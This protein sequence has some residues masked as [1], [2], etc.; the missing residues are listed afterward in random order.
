MRPLLVLRP[1]PGAS[2]TVAAGRILGLDTIAA[3]LFAIKPIGWTL[4]DWRPEAVLLTSANAVRHGGAALAALA[5]LPTYAVGAA[6]A[7]AAR[8]AGFTRIVSG[9]GD[10]EVILT[11]AQRD[12][13]RSL[14]HPTGREHREVVPGDIRIVRHIVYAAQAVEVLPEAARDAL[15]DAVALLHSSRA[16]RLFAGFVDPAGIAIA[17]ISPAVLAAAGPGWRLA[18]AADHPTDASLLAV[19]A[20]L[21]NHLS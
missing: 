5:D 18:E 1:E 8:N 15:P 21:C 17:A 16:A 13:I 12:G 10:V 2:A 7:E 6:T 20:K 4:P 3:P 11:L 9:D 14:L 19:A